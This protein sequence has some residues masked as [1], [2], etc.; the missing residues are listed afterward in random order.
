MIDV[1]RGIVQKPSI[2]DKQGPILSSHAKQEGTSYREMTES[3]II[4]SMAQP[5]EVI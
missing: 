3:A 5:Q 4:E 2:S 1:D